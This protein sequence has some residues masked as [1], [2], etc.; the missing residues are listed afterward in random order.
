[1]SQRPLSSGSSGGMASRNSPM[2]PRHV[3]GMPPAVPMDSGRTHEYSPRAKR[4][5]SQNLHVHVAIAL[6]MLMLLLNFLFFDLTALTVSGAAYPPATIEKGESAHL[7]L[8]SSEVQPGLDADSPEAVSVNAPLL[9]KDLPACA[10]SG[11]R[12]KSFLLLFMGH[13]MSS[14]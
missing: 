11:D 10:R 8:E 7:Q 3:N 2:L 13:C 9:A 1:M 4:R 14:S 6:F 5:V 12:A